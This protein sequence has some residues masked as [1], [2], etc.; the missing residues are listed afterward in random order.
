MHLCIF[1]YFLFI[2]NFLYGDYLFAFIFQ[3]FEML[4]EDIGGFDVLY[5]EMLACGIPTAVRLMWI[6]LSELSVRQQISVILGFPLRFLSDQWNSET[7]LTTANLIFD[8][9]KEMTDDIMT[10]IGFPIMEYILPDPVSLS[11]KLAIC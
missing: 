5:R 4:F 10:V 7:V 11:P 2:L 9:I 3:E 8:N 1:F 6:P